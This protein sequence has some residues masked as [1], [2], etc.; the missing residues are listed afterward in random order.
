MNSNIKLVN[1][2]TYLI[3]MLLIPLISKMNPAFVIKYDLNLILCLVLVIVNYQLISNSIKSFDNSYVKYA[4]LV[5]ILYILITTQLEV[6]YTNNSLGSFN[7]S[8]GLSTNAL[9]TQGI[10]AMLASLIIMPIINEIVFRASMLPE[11][12]S[13]AKALGMFLISVLA[14]A[15]FM[16]TPIVLSQVTI[17]TKLVQLTPLFIQAALA[18]WFYYFSNKNLLAV[19]MLN[20]CF[21]VTAMIIFSVM[22]FV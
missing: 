2:I 14:Y 9:L 18:S 19:I 17:G 16:G 6:L 3:F 13:G 22:A 1:V 7:R 20:I 5:I 21:N 8:L 10:G 15:Y 11:E 4:V 12:F